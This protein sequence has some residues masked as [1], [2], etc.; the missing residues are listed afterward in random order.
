VQVIDECILCVHGGLSPDIKTLDQV[1]TIERNQ[2]IPHKG[3]F[4]GILCQHY[5]LSCF[6][7]VISSRRFNCVERLLPTASRTVATFKSHLRTNLFNLFIKQFIS[8]AYCAVAFCYEHKFE[9][10]YIHPGH[11]VKL[12]PHRLKL[13]RIGCVGSGLVLAK[14]LT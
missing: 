4:C 3:A 1:R 5:L 7:A 6:F 2:E 12:H 8:R 10:S 14:A 9:L 11:D 13:Y